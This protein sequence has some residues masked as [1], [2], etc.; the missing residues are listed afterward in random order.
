V[1][2]PPRVLS[3]PGGEPILHYGA[4]AGRQLLVLQPLFEEMNRCRALVAALCRDLA[5]RGIGCWLPDL[6]GCGES[7]RALEEIGWAD[8]TGAVDHALALIAREG[9]GTAFG[10]VALRGGA[11]LDASTERRWRLSPVA[12]ASLVTDLRRSGLLAS[13]AYALGEALSGPL[14]SAEPDGAARVV[15]LTGDERPCDRSVDGPVLW[16]RPEP[17]AAPE[18]AAALAE[19]IAAWCDV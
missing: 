7:E 18:L 11:L 12:G 6:P 2:A 8:W 3:L 17:L 10:T 15:R 5:A 19:D 14:A 1:T 16:R 4:A 13:G 9:G